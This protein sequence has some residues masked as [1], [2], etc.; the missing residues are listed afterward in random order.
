MHEEEIETT[1]NKSVKTKLNESN[2]TYYVKK[3]N[4]HK[5]ERF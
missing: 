5:I 3:V 2:N 4:D 1:F